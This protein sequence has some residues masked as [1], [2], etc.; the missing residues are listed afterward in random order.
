M[1]SP[2]ASEAGADTA[3]GADGSAGGPPR[4]NGGDTVARAVEVLRA[5]PLGHAVVVAPDGTAEAE[6]FLS[7]PGLRDELQGAKEVQQRLLP[8]VVP[9]VPHFDFAGRYAAAG[10][11]GGDYWSV[12]FYREEGI[13]TCK[14][15]DVTGHGIG[16]AILMA[17]VK[18]VSGVLFRGS[19]SPTSVMERTNH[20]LLRETS[21]D[22]M[23]TMVYA[24]VYP[25]TR[26]VRLVN[27]GH[28]PAFLCRGATGAVED[29]PATGPL[30][31]LIETTY[32]EIA[33][34]LA[35]GDLLFFCSDGVAEAGDP[36]TFGE[37]RV[38]EIVREHRKQSAD[39]IADAVFAAARACCGTPR[40]DMSLL[41][42]KASE[43]KAAPG[44][45][46]KGRRAARSPD[47]P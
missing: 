5:S 24:W 34:T 22:K 35:P 43:V 39:A 18:F 19:T 12:K 4:L 14:L 32:D 26:R 42:I 45:A 47:V 21:P 8:R 38:K 46:Q 44:G 36:R 15:A 10:H 11:V 20:S 1:S 27:A 29:I 25:Q 37:A 7:E 33:V 2:S 16:A 3:A 40:D 41:V 28:S 9:T 23:A 6:L 13:V 30:L 17:A 31:G